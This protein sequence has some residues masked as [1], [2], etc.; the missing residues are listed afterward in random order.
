MSVEISS[1]PVPTAAGK[2]L[3]F[4]DV[5]Q[6]GAETTEL[7]AA[8]AGNKHKILG[9]ALTMSV[10]G[11]LKFT[12]GIDDLTGPFDI[13]S[14]GGFVLSTNAFPYFETG[15]ENRVVNLV[16]TLGAAHGVVI[17]LTEP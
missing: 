6:S 8:S 7:A 5:S 16:T 9:A 12:D 4:V 2:T 13:S 15:A 14:T 1:G 17:L 10:T 3:T 11:T